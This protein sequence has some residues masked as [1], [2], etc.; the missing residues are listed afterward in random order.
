MSTAVM[1]MS[2]A[3]AHIGGVPNPIMGVLEHFLELVTPTVSDK[4]QVVA[5]AQGSK[6]IESYGASRY[7]SREARECGGFKEP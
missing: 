2:T 7:R 3:L 6:C 1:G 5:R 4:R